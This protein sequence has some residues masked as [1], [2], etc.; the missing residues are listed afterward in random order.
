MPINFKRLAQQHRNH[1]YEYVK[2]YHLFWEKKYHFWVSI[3]NTEIE[4][5]SF[6]T[7][8]VGCQWSVV[9]RY[10]KR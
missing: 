1:R 8:F 9:R 10:I 2:E 3:L 6:T 5:T 4:K 7:P